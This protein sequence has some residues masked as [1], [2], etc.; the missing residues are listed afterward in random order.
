MKI[1]MNTHDSY[2][3]KRTNKV[4]LNPCAFSHA[5]EDNKAFKSMYDTSGLSFKGLFLA[6][7]QEKALNFIPKVIPEVSSYRS[8]LAEAIGVSIDRLSSVLAPDELRNILRKAKPEEFSTGENFENVLN[9]TF[10]INLHM[11]TLSDGVMSVKNCLYQ[12]A[13]YAEYRKSINKL[14]PV[15]VAITDHDMLSGVKEAIEIISRNPEKYKNIRFV[16]GIEFNAVHD[17]RQMEA[18][19]YCINPFDK[20]LNAFIDSS[21]EKNR[22]YLQGFIDEKVNKWESNAGIPPEKRTTLET[23]INN[24]NKNNIDGGKHLNYFGSP[25]LMYG[26]TNSLKNIFAARGWRFDGIDKFSELHGLKYGSFAINPGTP[27]LKGIIQLVNESSCGFVGVAHPCRNFDGV[28]LRVLFPTFK[29][30]GVEAVESNYQYPKNNSRFPKMFQDHVQLAAEQA[31]MLKAGG[32]DNHTDN[33][34]S[35]K[36]NI[37]NLPDTLQALIFSPYKFHSTEKYKLEKLEVAV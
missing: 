20:K 24:A 26:F 6:N 15:V 13:K 19:G 37:K 9:G 3:S 10:R 30:L 8:K 11:H 32:S 21:K 4:P 17:S 12:A 25:G 34:F 28:D 2:I 33:I 31:N 18:I 35:N 5:Q 14:D 7:V 1:T 29:R 27:D 22:K 16:P 23:V 36:F